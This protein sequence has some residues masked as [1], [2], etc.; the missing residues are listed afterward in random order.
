MAKSKKS[1]FKKITEFFEGVKAESKKVLW[2]SKENLVKYSIA[3]VLFMIFTCLFF[4]GTDLLIALL[5]YLKEI[6]A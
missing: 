1:L 2:T 4:V 5:A 6:I 3:T